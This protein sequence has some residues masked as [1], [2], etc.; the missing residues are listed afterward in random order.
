[1][2]A[3][4]GRGFEGGLDFITSMPISQSPSQP[5]MHHFIHDNNMKADRCATF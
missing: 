2:K 5:D 1:M 3:Q 4:R